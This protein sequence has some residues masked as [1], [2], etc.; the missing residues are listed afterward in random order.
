MTFR[1]FAAGCVLGALFIS[2]GAIAD[3]IAD[4]DPA[5]G[6]DY[7][8]E[9]QLGIQACEA[10]GTFSGPAKH[11][12]IKTDVWG[13]VAVAANLDWGY[14]YGYKTQK[15]AQNVALGSCMALHGA[16]CKLAVT[17]PGYCVSLAMSNGDRKWAVSSITG[18]LNVAESDSKFHCAEASCAIAVSFCADGQRHSWQ[19]RG[20]EKP[21]VVQKNGRSQNAARNF[22]CGGIPGT[23]TIELR[24]DGTYGATGSILDHV[25]SESGRFTED[26]RHVTLSGIQS[27]EGL[28]EK[29][30]TN[31]VLDKLENG[32]LKWILATCKKQ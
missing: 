18:A 9:M 21:E 25:T 13:A 20:G 26:A 32:D 1:I 29:E 16:D 4:I 24:A 28:A 17:V 19:P 11:K 5:T 8:C 15:E 14:S 2:V 30:K 12:T 10:L 6:R 27:V 3:Q 7:S 23:K 22:K 31:M